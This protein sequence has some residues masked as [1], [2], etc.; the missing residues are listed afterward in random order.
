MLL[1]T[2]MLHVAQVH[3]WE[4]VTTYDM[5]SLHWGKVADMTIS[6]E[7][8]VSWCM[9][10][11]DGRPSEKRTPSQ[12]RPLTGPHFLASENRTTFQQRAK[13]LVPKC[14]YLGGSTV[15][16]LKTVPKCPYLGGSTV[17][18]LK[19]VSKCPYLGG[20]TVS[21]LKTP[22]LQY[23]FQIAASYSQTNVLVWCIDIKVH[24]YIIVI[25]N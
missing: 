13:W 5:L 6:K 23:F 24:N 11:D 7:Q 8:L 20:S 1:T 14:P 10:A 9:L 17:S 19:T 2:L 25:R 4:P 22:Q 3:G 18:L 15:S 16:L 12:Q 21:L